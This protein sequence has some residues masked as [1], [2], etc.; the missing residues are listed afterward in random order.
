LNTGGAKIAGSYNDEADG[1]GIIWTAD[2]NGKA[3]DAYTPSSNVAYKFIPALGGSTTA[4]TIFA[5]N[6]PYNIAIDSTGS[7]WATVPVSK[8]VVQI[9]GSAAP[10]WP[11]LSLGT[12]GRP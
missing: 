5:G 10:T 6:K 11:L 3:I 8:N 12:V 7:I 9:I 1:D 4:A 2:V